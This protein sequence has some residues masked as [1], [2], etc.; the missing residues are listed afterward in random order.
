ME[1]RP[2]A[3]PEPR[4]TPFGAET[5]G[6]LPDPAVLVALTAFLAGLALY[7]LTAA[8][9]VQGGD[10]GEFQ[11]VG[12]I[13][14][15]PHPPGYPLYALV[16]KLWT[17]VVPVGEVARR[18]NLLSAVLGAATL[19]AV[20]LAAARVFGRFGGIAAGLVAASWLAVAPTWWG[21]ATIASIR[22]TTGF[23][24]AAVL[25][26]LAAY[27]VARSPRWLYGA[28]ALF[29]LGVAHHVSLPILAPA[30]VLYV[31]ATSPLVVR[32]GRVLVRTAV[33]AVLPL[34]LFL[35]LPIRSAS[36]S[37]FDA[38]HP[39]TPRA[40]FDLVTARGF[41]GDMLHFDP[42]SASRLEL[43]RQILLTN[44]GSLGLALALGGGLVTLAVRP[45]WA[46]LTG[47]VA[48]INLFISLSYRAP[49]I[50]DY[51]IPTSVVFALWIGALAALP[52][53]LLSRARLS[54]V[55]VLAGLALA[56]PAAAYGQASWASFD[57]SR[58]TADEAFLRD[59]FAAAA[60]GSTILTDWYHATVLW[61]GQLARAERRDLRVD[62][63][64]PS[65]A[66]VP[67][68]AKA[69]AALAH[70]PVYATA[71]DPRLGAAHHLQR[72]GPLYQVLA[73]PSTD[74]PPGLNPSGV[75]FGDT[76]EL[77][78]YR[79]ETPAAGEDVALTLAWRAVRAL[80][81]D[82]SEFVHVVGPDGHVWGQR[83]GAPGEGLYPTSRWRPGEVV[84]ERYG[85]AV[86][87]SAPAGELQVEVGFYE[88]Q[89]GGGWT[90]LEARDGGG[91]QLGDAA[92]IARVLVTPVPV[93]PDPR[94]IALGPVQRALGRLDRVVRGD[95][96]TGAPSWAVAS[97]RTW[98]PLG[99]RIVLAGW[100]LDRVMARPGNELRVAL[101]FMPLATTTDDDAV[102]VHL[103]DGNGQMRVQSDSVPA[104]GGLPTLRWAP[105][106]A[107][108]DVRVLRLPADLP[109]GEYRLRA[110]MYV[111]A[112]GAHVPVLDDELA[113]AGQGDFVD[114]AAVRVQP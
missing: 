49:V 59:A 89:P 20:A 83:D 69:D 94:A 112:T 16:S 47:G 87:P 111:M 33:A 72:L 39:T 64:A 23:L 100:A 45:R 66:D 105:G 10:S 102:F 106:R 73:V 55:G 44:F 29:G 18:V 114:L 42:L 21:Q 65:G 60:P 75:R 93:P 78:G 34:A 110:G 38:S 1:V 88:P 24:L 3:P 11:F 7:G 37:E 97:G 27:G 86:A 98:V 70:G 35:Y 32:D 50:A 71:L 6:R 9:G 109:S 25:A 57:L 85:F 101:D 46:L 68:L 17:L 53:L 61:Y 4:S 92:R 62:Y 8:P 58:D 19:G 82:V 13:L 76:I 51:L 80:D 28:A 56:I 52:A 90:R 22:P 67:W 95:G 2:A 113:K 40:F 103:V 107:V 91:A 63:V 14:G 36:G 31:V 74:V 79:M 77:A 41:A 99:H 12:Y 26:A 96:P 81:R 108:R 104:D 43:G 54:A 15:I 5:T 30:F 84:I 48:L